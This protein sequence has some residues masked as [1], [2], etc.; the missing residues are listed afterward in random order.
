MA[1]N[2]EFHFTQSNLQD[3]I[4]C[5]RRFELRYMDQRRWPAVQSEPALEQEKQMLLG[6]RFH[7]MVHQYC[8]SIPVNPAA[9]AQQDNDL[10]FWWQQF[11]QYNPFAGLPAARYPE[12]TLSAHLAGFRLVAKYDLLAI[13]PGKS[14][15][16]VDWKTG[17]PSPANRLKQ[18]VQS[19]LYPY[20]VVEACAYLNG[21]IP[22]Q[23][24][25]VQMMYWF[26]LQP[27]SPV[28]FPYHQQSYTADR[29][30]FSNLI[31]EINERP[32]GKFMLTNDERAC[33][34]CIYRS[35]CGR[36][37]KAGDW[38]ELPDESDGELPSSLDFDIDQIGAIAY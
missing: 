3:Y 6:Q 2:S 9:I 22:V 12:H 25:Q 8:L 32:P 30:F 18:R 28:V 31:R 10:A 11:I 17:A 29:Q 19:H 38:H 1:I 35:L 4:A 37:D 14:I 34:F 23:P 13:D 21:G 24:E 33:Q 27:D 15:V 16:I 26:A 7:Q 36:G 5:P 20:L